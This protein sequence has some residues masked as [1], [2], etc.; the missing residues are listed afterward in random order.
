MSSK[1]NR[2]VSITRL[3]LTGVSFFAA[4]LSAAPSTADERELEEV[5]ITATLMD[6]DVNRISATTLTDEDVEARGAAHFEDL[7][8]L[9]PNISASS[10]ASRQRFFQIRGIGERSQFIEPVNPSVVLLQDGVDISGLGGA[11]T[12]FDT[13]QIDILRGPQG[14]IMGAGALAGLISVETATPSDARELNIAMGMENYG[15]RRLEVSGNTPIT[16]ALSA[17]VAH[18]RY[19]SDGWVDNTHLG[20]NDTNNRDEQTT[21]V[22]L[23]RVADA[24]TVDIKLNKVEVDNGYDAFSLDNTRETLSDQPGEDS[25]DMTSMLVR[26]NRVGERFTSTI[27]VSD[28]DA[29]AIYSYDEDWSFVGIRPFWEYSSFDQYTRDIERSTFEWRLSPSTAESLDW[30]VGVYSREDSETLDRDY[31]YLE[32]PFSSFNDTDTLAIYGQISQTLSDDVTLTLGAR[33]EQRDVAYRDSAGVRE[34]FDDNYWTGNASINWQVSETSA[35][36]ATISRGVR[37]GGVNASLSSTLLT[38]ANEIDVTP[39][40]N[41]T[42][43][44]EESLLNT[45]MGYRFSSTDQRISGSVTIFNMDR[46]D[47]QVKGS[48]VIPRSDG[49]TS[50]TDFTDNAASGT[51]RGLE[52]SIDWRATEALRFSGFIAR[53]DA[54]FDRYVN[55]DGT[56]L[57]GRDQPQ[58]PAD[59]YRL[60]A[61]YDFSAN[62]SASLEATGRDA[63]FLSD[64]HEVTSPS[65]RLINANIAWQ[66]GAWAVTLWGRNLQDKTTVT[67]G[68]GTFGNDPRKDYAL[69]PYY[70]FGE[71]RTVGATVRY[72]FGG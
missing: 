44:D 54:S 32:A 35:L 12:S 47:Q 46:R 67:R 57:S 21:R 7:L 6:S 18:Q 28:V 70:Q 62:L 25:L 8:S 66:R 11:L 39:Y 59:Q 23:R 63:F 30:V 55:I 64:R 9:V 58:A 20:V 5:T 51:N 19:E 4:G 16:P 3:V 36:F 68:F 48:L 22:A 17:R 13:A 27:Q 34:R 42:R 52:A 61:I 31:T 38:L 49:S 53:L 24:N 41:S 14:A 37:A 72:Q 50:F 26:W 45:E 40:R 43:F 29:D 10:G 33:F 69:E 15:G 56:D 71:P 1:H 2:Y 60:S 65:A